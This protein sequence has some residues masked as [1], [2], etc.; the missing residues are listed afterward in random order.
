M[1]CGSSDNSDTQESAVNESE[2]TSSDKENEAD[3]DGAEV[4][5]IAYQYGL[6]YAPLII[7]QKQELVEKYYEEGTIKDRFNNTYLHAKS[8]LIKDTDDEGD[9]LCHLLAIY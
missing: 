2:D 7:M 5:N 1:G 6:A 4:L 9:K 3:T 8:I